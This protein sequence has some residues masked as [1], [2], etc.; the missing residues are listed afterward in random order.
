MAHEQEIHAEELN[1]KDQQATDTSKN[2]NENDG[3]IYEKIFFALLSVVEHFF[4]QYYISIPFSIFYFG[5]IN[6][7]AVSKE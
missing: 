1:Q 7:N 4:N 3:S 5:K 2:Y 6:L